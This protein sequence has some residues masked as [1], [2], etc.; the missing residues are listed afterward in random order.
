[1]VR[2]TAFCLFSLLLSVPSIAAEAGETVSEASLCQ[3]LHDPGAYNHKLIR[4]TG[5]VSRGFEDF[6]LHDP[7]CPEDKILTIVWLEYGGAKPAQVKFC[8][9]ASDAPNKPNG[10]QPLWVDGVETPLLRD[11]MFG[12]FERLTVHLRRGE[13]IRA[14]LVGRYFSG[15][16]VELPDGRVSWEGF[17]H[18]GIASLFVIQQVIAAAR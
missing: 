1:V 13:T 8:C 14:R 16:K 4:V 3:L 6:S 11:A 9:V 10:K 12:K 7:S 15:D 17:G 18:F 5:R 2:V